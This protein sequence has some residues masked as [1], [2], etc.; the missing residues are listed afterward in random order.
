MTS[1]T[2]ALL[3]IFGA[4]ICFS[5]MN[6]LAKIVGQRGVPFLEIAFARALVS[7]LLI[8]AYMLLKKQSFAIKNKKALS[9]RIFFGVTAMFA[10]FY[11]LTHMPLAESVTLFNTRPIFIAL[12]GWLWLKEKPSTK[13]S[14][15][16]VIA[17]IGVWLIFNPDTQYFKSTLLALYAGIAMAIAMLALRK[18]GTSDQPLPIILYFSLWATLGTLIFG[19]S[20]FVLLDPTSLMLLILMGATVTLA[21]V[22][23][24]R[25]Y[26]LTQA[27][28]VG[29][30][31]S[32]AVV[33]SVLFGVFFFHETLS[34]QAVLGIALVVTSCLALLKTRRHHHQA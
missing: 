22:L 24:T 30:G 23:M 6:I 4:A 7:L 14:T 29:A 18:L 20:S 8:Y 17:F 32:I 34:S 10:V 21:Q 3:F 26:A 11:A 5:L 28:I 13:T 25:A 31:S 15:S 12:L 9:I 27:A 16:I 2:K 19:F 1:K 33:V